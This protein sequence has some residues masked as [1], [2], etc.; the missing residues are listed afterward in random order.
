MERDQL[1]TA[2]RDLVSRHM[3]KTFTA[4][5]VVVYHEQNVIFREAFGECKLSSLFD[6]ASISKLFTVAAFM[7]L[8]ACR[9]VSLDDPV[10][11]I[12]PEFSGARSRH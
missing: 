4:A 12:I 8:V 7:S 2:I 10:A 5:A 1:A 6:L 3:T 11:K 9:R